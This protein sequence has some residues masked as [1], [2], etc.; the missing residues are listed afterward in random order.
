MIIGYKQFLEYINM[1]VENL[2]IIS[3]FHRS[4]HFEL[5][6]PLA[7]TTQ[8]G[9]DDHAIFLTIINL[10]IS[11]NFGLFVLIKRPRT[12]SSIIYFFFV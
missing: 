7:S 4:M 1:P 5:G 3:K 8:K 11:I 6:I 9:E 2:Q 12:Y 10:I